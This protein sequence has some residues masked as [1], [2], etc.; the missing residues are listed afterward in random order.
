MP[1]SG[2][3]DST[4][5]RHVRRLSLNKRRQWV[6]V[7]NSVYARSNDDGQAMRTANGV[8]RGKAI[9]RGKQ[10]NH[11]GAMLAL[12]PPI[13]SA[14]DLAWPGGEP[15]DELH[16]TLLYLG[17]AA[18]L[19]EQDLNRVRA[20]AEKVANQHEPIL[21]EIGGLGRFFTPDSDGN[22]AVIGLVDHPDL[23]AMRNELAT[24]L[25]GLYADNHGFSPHMTLAYVPAD[26]PTPE[27][28][29]QPGKVLFSGIWLFLA[30]ER[31]EYPFKE[32]ATKA[33][34]SKPGILIDEKFWDR[35]WKDVQKAFQP[36]VVDVVLAGGEAA[37]NI[38]PIVSNTKAMKEPDLTELPPNY[39]AVARNAIY[40]FESD[41]YRSLDEYTRTS[42]RD[43]ISLARFEGHPIEWIIDRASQLFSPERAQRIAVTETTRLM[44]LGAQATY[45]ES[46]VVEKWAWQ[47]VEDAFVCAECAAVDGQ[48]YDIT[49]DFEPLHPNCRCFPRPVVSEPEDAQILQGEPPDLDAEIDRLND[50]Y[51]TGESSDYDYRANLSR[52]MNEAYPNTIF[53]FSGLEPLVASEVARA[54]NDVLTK[55]PEVQAT[56]TGVEVTPMQRLPGGER[57]TF[58]PTTFAVTHNYY[59]GTPAA[60]GPV[61]STVI[62]MN[63]YFFTDGSKLI[64]YY[65][66]D[67]Q[68][69]YHP[70]SGLSSARSIN[71]HELG[72][73]VSALYHDLIVYL[74]NLSYEEALNTDVLG[75]YAKTNPEEAFAEAFMLYNSPQRSKLPR[76]LILGFQALDERIA[77]QA[78]R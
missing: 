73:A 60:P 62:A 17:D 29:F 42:L 59:S 66:N 54:Y 41:F 30:G 57:Y 33:R 5:P 32:P 27:N 8:V 45:R 12:V 72:H 26:A 34:R 7:F 69:G 52:F 36:I 51:Y 28:A 55:Y 49:L 35:V 44:G 16:V 14:M 1:Y 6:S 38:V 37:A 31:Y 68:V 75:T 61:R 22:N 56:L 39:D 20:A 18:K 43:T 48:E 47:T 40:K 74:N 65:Q 24:N 2:A 25:E 78:K 10:A 70:D 21:A 11:T 71:L 67:I 23:P 58:K 64:D 13:S 3:S 50:A 46:G 15:A 53:D 63:P 9:Y 77:A 76:S 19:T 4:L